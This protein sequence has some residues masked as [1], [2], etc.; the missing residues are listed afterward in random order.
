ML[1]YFTLGLVVVFFSVR[2]VVWRSDSAL[3]PKH[4]YETAIQVPAWCKSAVEKLLEAQPSLMLYPIDISSHWDA[5]LQSIA[6]VGGVNTS[7]GSREEVSRSIL[8]V[9]TPA[10]RD[11]SGVRAG[12]MLVEDLRSLSKQRGSVTVIL[13]IEGDS[14]KVCLLYTSPSPRDQRGSRMPSSA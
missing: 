11:Y 12:E 13:S 14:I 6:I 7:V 1:L 5:A 3:A 10:R 8:E 4:Q 2:Q 9:C